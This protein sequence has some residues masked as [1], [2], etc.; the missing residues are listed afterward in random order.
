MDSAKLTNPLAGALPPPSR[1]PAR[2]HD[3]DYA[4]AGG[5]LAALSV[6]MPDAAR[7]AR[8]AEAKDSA[9]LARLL[10]EAGYPPAEDPETS[11]AEGMAASDR[12]LR[13]LCREGDGGFLDLLLTANDAHNLK[14]FLKDLSVFWPDPGLTVSDGGFSASDSAGT[15]ASLPSG[16]GAGLGVPLPAVAREASYVRVTERV[17][18]PSTYSPDRL[19]EAV[20]DAAMADVP[21]WLQDA[22]SSAY[23]VY[24]K[25]GDAYRIDSAIDRAQAGEALRLAKELNCPWVTGLMQL[26]TD[27]VNL[28]VLLRVRAA[29]LDRD[30]LTQSLLPGGTVPELDVQRLFDATDEA[31]HDRYRMTGCDEA[32][33]AGLS[34]DSEGAG[35][36]SRF[37][38]EADDCLMRYARTVKSIPYGP[39]WLVAYRFA[40]ETEAR[41]FRI[42]MMFLRNGL[43]AESAQTLLREP[44]VR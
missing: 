40:K 17:L 11:L 3:V 5:R 31:L 24:M 7:T 2:R 22:A 10:A 35:L 14:L 38:K 6:R 18:R 39:E 33:T 16:F 8:L 27:L 1:R 12:M 20:R 23:G 41:N 44:F 36:A 37:G 32:L 30:V 15:S 34:T 4:F 26:R 28:G 9:D 43:P 25:T 13:D 21:F 29:R 42:V 19:F